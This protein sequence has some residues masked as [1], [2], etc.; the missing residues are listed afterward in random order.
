MTSSVGA[1]NA[2]ATSFASYEQRSTQLEASLVVSR[3]ETTTSRPVAQTTA[4]D[5]SRIR[6][7]Q[8][9]KNILQFVRE[10]LRTLRAEGA[11]REQLQAV[12]E[13]AREGFRQGLGE[14]RDALGEAGK[15]ERNE[16]ALER[17]ERRVERGLDRLE[18]RFGGA[19]DDALASA[20]AD[21]TRDSVL[22]QAAINNAQTDTRAPSIAATA[23]PP[24]PS[25]GTANTSSS[26]GDIASAPVAQRPGSALIQ[27]IA[28]YREQLSRQQSI[29]FSLR[30][31]DGDTITLRF[32]AS[33][34][35]FLA[36]QSQFLFAGGN[37]F[38]GAQL[39]SQVLGGRV[40]SQNL[41][42][43]I[44]GDI[45]EEERGA[46]AAL[47]AQLNDVASNFFSGN[48][49]QALAQA[50]A[51]EVDSSEIAGFSLDLL[52]RELQVAT[53]QYREVAA[54][55]SGENATGS[56]TLGGLLEQLG[57]LA[58]ANNRT[59]LSESLVEKLLAISFAAQSSEAVD[60]DSDDAESAN[61]AG[62]DVEPER[63]D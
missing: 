10:R 13:Q 30:T 19:D 5:E 25:T 54:V 50:L 18:R 40:S 61:A 21:R 23:T 62:A 22:A 9:A 6:P 2:L 53:A 52:A 33:E 14:A 39:S 31:Q 59:Q 4:A 45:D 48:D 29:E 34:Q 60:G 63:D 36:G 56:N 26:E 20:I 15:L 35:R 3:S 28:E 16:R 43:E 47:L 58:V 46:I 24:A 12:I 8:V 44:V 51:L 32:N 57:A 42:I 55:T 1:S 17:I 37:G 7:G 27:R 11:D 49:G 38:A 41:Q